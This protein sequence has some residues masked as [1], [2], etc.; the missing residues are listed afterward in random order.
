MMRTL[1]LASAAAV[2]MSGSFANA[3][4]LLLSD[5]NDNKRVVNTW[6]DRS[7]DRRADIHGGQV[8]TSTSQVRQYNPA[9]PQTGA[10]GVSRGFLLHTDENDNKRVENQYAR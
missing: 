6:V 8:H 10:I 7:S 4:M 2:L 1:F 9:A 3:G 5:E